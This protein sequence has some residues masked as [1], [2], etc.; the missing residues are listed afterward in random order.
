M[1]PIRW[2]G[3]AQRLPHARIDPRPDRPAFFADGMRARHHGRAL[4]W[5]EPVGDG[6]SR[7]PCSDGRL[8]ATGST[9]TLD[10]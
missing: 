3:Q 2:G 4:G 5:T 7:L 6:A 10:A 8:A 9:G 1:T